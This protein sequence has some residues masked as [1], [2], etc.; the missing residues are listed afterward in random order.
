MQAS[1]AMHIFR[2][3]VCKQARLERAV[4]AA[5]QPRA[6]SICHFPRERSQA[7]LTSMIF[8]NLALVVRTVTAGS[9]AEATLPDVSRDGLSRRRLIPIKS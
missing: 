9:L 8:S 3:I 6:S 7:A 1:V 4:I 2:V 5:D